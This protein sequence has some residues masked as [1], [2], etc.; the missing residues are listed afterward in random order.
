MLITYMRSSSY[1]AFD[2]CQ[3][4]YYIEY[5]LGWKGKSNLAAD[6]GTVVHKIL[7]ILA[8]R[9]KGKQEGLDFIEDEILGKVSTKYL[10]LDKVIDDVYNYYSKEFKQHKWTG[11]HYNDCKKWTY[12]ALEY[13]NGAYDPRLRHIV[14][15]EM[16]FDFLFEEEW[17]KYSYTVGDKKF[18]GQFGVKG[19]VDLITQVNP[20]FYEIID[21]KTG[22]RKNWATGEKKT[23]EKLEDDPQLRLYHYAVHKMFPEV[24][25][26]MVTIF[27]IKDGGPFSLCYDKSEL[28]RTEDM[29]R[30]RFEKIRDTTKPTNRKGDAPCKFCSYAKDTYEGTP[31][32]VM[33]EFRDGQICKKDKKMTICEQTDLMLDLYGID[34]VTET[35]RHPYNDIGHYKAPGT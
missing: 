23:Y 3:L 25:Q 24:E 27:F 31:V 8:V 19:T 15:P 7:E 34:Q 29:I 6:K 33:T 16:H 22:Q 5:V 11:Y 10:K 35:S 2:M 21:W 20:K 4:R 32:E 17:A 26:V 12:Q 14:E 9:K 18:E 13:N 30:T 28:Q 1:N